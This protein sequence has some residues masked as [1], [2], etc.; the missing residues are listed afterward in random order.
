[1][2]TEPSPVTLAEVVRRAVEICDPAGE[3][4]A[5][6]DPPPDVAAWLSDRG[7]EL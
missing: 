5:L 2:P 4:E 3:A 6:A 1:M 7:V